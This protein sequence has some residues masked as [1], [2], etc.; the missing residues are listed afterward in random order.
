MFKHKITNFRELLFY[1][2]SLNNFINF[3]YWN[4]Y[5]MSL[6]TLIEYL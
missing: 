4:M 3:A 5:R 1:L 6:L 2:K